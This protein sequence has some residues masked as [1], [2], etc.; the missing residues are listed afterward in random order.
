MIR[1]R[2][3]F[4]V[5]PKLTSHCLII[6]Q[7]QPA[8]LRCKLRL[9]LNNREE[10]RLVL[11]PQHPRIMDGTSHRLIDREVGS[12]LVV[13][14]ACCPSSNAG[15]QAGNP[16]NDSISVRHKNSPSGGNSCCVSV[17]LRR[18]ADDCANART[19]S[20]GNQRTFD[21]TAKHRTQRGPGCSPNQSALT[22]AD[23]ALVAIIVVLVIS[24]VV[25]AAAIISPVGAASRSVVKLVV[26]I[27]SILGG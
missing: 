22:R 18:L 13:E 20:A 5:I 24:V 17:I 26:V 2:L 9:R 3:R 8:L 10:P 6:R 23:T 4:D 11:S 25:V 27:S 7:H 15:H 19:C 14:D 12:R 21:S 1:L 16:Q